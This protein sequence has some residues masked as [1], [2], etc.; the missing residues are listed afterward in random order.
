MPTKVKICGITNL[1]DA[2]FAVEAGAD[3]LG[4]IFFDN[5]PRNL[6]PED[7][8]GIIEKLPPF[9][10]A[11]GVFVNE[12]PG[13]IRDIVRSTGLNAVQ[14]HGD[15]S[16]GFCKGLGLKAIKAFRVRVKDDI[17]RLKGYEVSAFLLDTFKE[18][19]HGGTGETF[20]WDIAIKA[21]RFG[22][23]ILSG[24]LTPDNI[25]EAV[26]KAAPYAVDVSSG[27][28]ERPGKKDLKKVRK[29][30]EQVKGHETATR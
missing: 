11:V 25:R 28:E 23:I 3:A 26:A 27:V 22:R 24:G 5:S 1:D 20:D 16:P 9:V 2:L 19:V 30:I 14:L 29:F 6:R 17:N 4:F 12:T 7:A 8:A 18:G 21:K 10:T 13:R 15:E